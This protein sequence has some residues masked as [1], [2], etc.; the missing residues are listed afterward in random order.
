VKIFP[1]S[2]GTRVYVCDGVGVFTWLQCSLNEHVDSN[3]KQ[4]DG[5]CTQDARDPFVF[6]RDRI[7]SV[8]VGMSQ[9]L[10]ID[11]EG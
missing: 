2:S 8:I 1:F 9:C 3:N 7:S 5:K 6:P 10:Q 4:C 11:E